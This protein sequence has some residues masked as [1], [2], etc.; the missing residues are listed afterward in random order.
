MAAAVLLLR[1]RS[2]PGKEYCALAGSRLRRSGS[3]SPSAFSPMGY[4][5]C[6]PCC[7]GNRLLW[8]ERGTV[9]GVVL[10]TLATTRILLQLHRIDHGQAAIVAFFLQYHRRAKQFDIGRTG[11]PA[12]ALAEVIGPVR[13]QHQRIATFLFCCLTQPIEY[14][15]ITRSPRYGCSGRARPAWP[16]RAPAGF[17]CNGEIRQHDH[18]AWLFG[19]LGRQNRQCGSDAGLKAGFFHGHLPWVFLVASRPPGAYSYTF[20]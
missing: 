2:R 20:R 3:R 15:L 17:P 19:S 18:L 12:R 10:L 9:T 16:R 13:A 5:G 11:R 14:P 1:C 4:G 7:T 6:R 8:L